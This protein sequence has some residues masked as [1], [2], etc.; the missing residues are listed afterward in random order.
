M[1]TA[2]A[3]HAQKPQQ[4]HLPVI[5]ALKEAEARGL[6]VQDSSPWLD[7]NSNASRNDAGSETLSCCPSPKVGEQSENSSS[8]VS[9]GREVGDVNALWVYSSKSTLSYPEPDLLL[10][11]LLF[12]MREYLRFYQYC[13]FLLF[14]STFGK[15]SVK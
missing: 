8:F 15:D 2:L 5:P 9:S 10:S 12:L 6:G 3:Q 1:G 11:L 13:Y 14:V 4:W 7:T